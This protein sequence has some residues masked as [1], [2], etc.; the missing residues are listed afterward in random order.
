MTILANIVTDL[1]AESRAIAKGKRKT[2]NANRRD[3]I[4]V[5]NNSMWLTHSVDNSC[6][7][8]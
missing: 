6:I 2:L 4:T 3:T 8:R 7:I 5:T 1:L